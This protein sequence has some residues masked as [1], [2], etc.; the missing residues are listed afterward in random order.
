MPARG[1][2]A[3]QMVGTVQDASGAVIVNATVTVT[4]QKTG[5]TWT[6][7]TDAKGEFKTADLPPG[8][9]TVSVAQSGFKTAARRDVQLGEGQPLTVSFKL[10][11]APIVERMEDTAKPLTDPVYNQLRDIGFSGEMAVVSDLALKRDAGTFQLRQGTLYFFSPVMN[12][13]TGAVFVGEGRFQLRPPTQIERD[14]LRH[15]LTDAED[16]A[17][18]DEPF[19][20]LILYFTDNTYEELKNK[21][22]MQPGQAP[23]DVAGKFKDHQKVLRRQLRQTIEIRLLSD[24]Y[25]PQRSPGQANGGSAYGGSFTSFIKGKKHDKLIFGIDP[26]GFVSGLGPEE[27][28][29]LSYGESDGGLWSLFHRQEE[30]ARQTASSDE[31]H[32]EYDITHHRIEA[33][34]DRGE[35]LTASATVTFTPRMPGLR[36]VPFSLFSRLEVG[37]V[38]NEMGEAVPFVQAHHEEGGAF[39]VIFPEPLA[40]QA[41]SVTIEYRGPEAVKDSGGG[42][43]ILL[44]RSTWYP[45]NWQTDFGDRATF[46]MT[47]RTPRNL[48]MIAT[49]RKVREWQEEKYTASQWVSEFPLTVAGFNYGEFRTQQQNEKGFDIA[50]YTNRSEP[51]ELKAIQHAAEQLQREGISIDAPLGNLS[52][53]G[54]AKSALA[55]AINSIRIFNQYFGANPYTGL[56]MS[57]QPAGFFGQSWPMLV[58]MPYTAFLDATQRHALGLGRGFTEQFTDIVGPHEVAHQWWGHLVVWKTYHDQWLSE[59]FAEFSAALYLLM[60]YN[61]DP[62]K[63]YKRFLDFWRDRRKDVVEKKLLG[64]NRTLMQPNSVGP[65]WLGGRLDNARTGGASRWVIYSKGAFVLHMLRMMM[66]QDERFIPMMRDFVQTHLHQAASTEDFKRIVEK[67]MTPEMDLERNGRMDWFFTQWVYGTDLPHYKAE[68]SFGTGEGGQT[69]LKLKITQS[70]VSDNFRML[71]PIYLDYGKDQIARLGTATLIGN[72]SASHDI[73]LQKKP[74][75]VMLCANEDVLCTKEE[76]Q[77]K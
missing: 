42:N 11:V 44:P 2:A 71:I 10:D 30:Y 63:R 19:D 54:L 60:A 1:S 77:V 9:Y 40:Q 35:Q 26:L 41:H 23:S 68:Y 38:L 56:V 65:L 52:T 74:R 29:L 69:L 70:N 36:V 5:Q 6:V 43:F 37:R 17:Q 58:Y 8:T 59:G 73:P 45:N 22:K 18:I 24:L 14:V 72:S 7:L 28:G 49:A 46:D 61:P 12:R 27:V 66:R 39:A 62:Q 34:I 53:A 51:D 47:F 31:D 4:N 76:V 67:H 55:E 13:V 50:V 20:Q 15:L 75:R 57:Q 16:K 32:R 25:N 48:T 21:V 64:A 33:V 3:T